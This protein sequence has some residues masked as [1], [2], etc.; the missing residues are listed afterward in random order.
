VEVRQLEYL[1]AVAEH[2]S[3]TLAAEVLGVSQPSVSQGLRALENELGVVLVDRLPR[4]AQLTAAGR[5]MQ[6]LA[7]TALRDV[8][9]ARS[10]V[11]AVRGLEAGSL[12]L[13]CLPT[14]A[15]T[16]TAR[17]V[18][19]FRAAHPGIVV[20]IAQPET[21]DDLLGRVR[22]GRSEVAV[23]ELP[24]VVEGL[25]FRGLEVQDFVALVPAAGARA[26]VTAS[27]LAELPLITSPIGTSTRR[28]LEELFALLDRTPRVM[29]ETEHREA[30]VQLVAAGAGVAIVPRPLEPPT[31]GSGVVVAEVRPLLRRRIGLVYRSAQL[32]PAAQAFVDLAVGD[33]PKPPSRPAARRR[34]P[35]S[36][37]S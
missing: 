3:F 8:A 21:V 37:R 6:P 18:G 25:T 27:E 15:T 12:D 13:V 35:R 17:L 30:F 20:R 28:Q 29:V 9:A 24:V 2:G 33:A 34:R 16:P 4:G 7:Q 5:A 1:L 32:A 26:T 31:A 23:T 36:T 22:D 19:M 11:D 14:L 10:A